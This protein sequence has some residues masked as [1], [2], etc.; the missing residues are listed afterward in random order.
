MQRELTLSDLA[1]FEKPIVMY[2]AGYPAD[3]LP[4]QF[5]TDSKLSKTQTLQLCVYY[6]LNPDSNHFILNVPIKS[7]AKILSCSIKTVRNNNS[8]FSDNLFIS[9]T[10]N[11]NQT[12]S[13][14]LHIKEI[15]IDEESLLLR[16]N[17]LLKILKLENINS[18]RI[19]FRFILRLYEKNKLHNSGKI[20]YSYNDIL[21]FLPSNINHPRIINQLVGELL[22]IFDIKNSANGYFVSY[23]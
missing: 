6:F 14:K 2:L 5:A 9:F 12:L 18:I 10:E 22:E 17:L 16:K 23:K 7:L 11:K 3:S 21:N 4:I 1:G 8:S 20:Y 15:L 19:A 13:L